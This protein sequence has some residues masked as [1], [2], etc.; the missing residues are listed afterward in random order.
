MIKVVLDLVS[1]L[2]TT[3]PL[4]FSALFF[5]LVFILL[6]KSIKKYYYV[7]YT[8][9][10]IPFLLV[11]VPFFLR[12]CGVETSF[13]FTRIPVLGEIL[14]D[15]IHMGSLGH[16]LLIVIMYM[17]ALDTR[18]TY[19]KRLMSIRKEISIISGFPILT[20]SL[21]RSFNNFPRALK[22]FTN[23]NEFMENSN[24]PSALGVGISNTVLV[25]GIVMLVL[26]F[27]LW[28]TSF[29]AV[30]RRMGGVKWKKVQKWSYVL[31]ALLF[32]HAMGIVVGGMMNPRGGHQAAAQATVEVTAQAT[33]PAAPSDEAGA[34]GER[35]N[36]AQGEHATEVSQA[37][38][39]PEQNGEATGERRGRSNREAAA[40][41]QGGGERTPH[42]ARAEQQEKAATTAQVQPQQQQGHTP[43]KGLT[44]IQ[45]SQEARQWISFWSLILIYGSYLI[46]R[47]RKARKKAAK[48]AAAFSGK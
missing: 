39:S 43:T 24:A 22:Y 6:A 10:A 31:Y 27:V 45:I 15:Y 26:F 47:V 32:I 38:R 20:H 33:A 28:V 1:L 14:R 29:D 37:G 35:R 7:Y 16:P 19:V 12:L 4:L 30:H 18:K 9:F 23:H 21:I 11:A 3:F 42:A 8:L 46:L 36:R 44:D 17:G 2:R 13:N 48:K 41:E 34:R 40:S 5:A 25:L